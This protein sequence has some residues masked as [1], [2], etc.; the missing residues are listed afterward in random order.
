MNYIRTISSL[1]QGDLLDPDKGD[2]TQDSSGR[3]K[4]GPHI[5]NEAKACRNEIMKLT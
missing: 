3:T 5:L 2:K 4:I 1:A